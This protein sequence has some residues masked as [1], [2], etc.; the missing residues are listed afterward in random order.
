M[1]VL[2]FVS[3]RKTMRNRPS[4]I[5]HFY[6]NGTYSLFFFKKSYR[7][8]KLIINKKFVMILKW[9]YAFI[10][11]SLQLFKIYA[12][13]LIAHSHSSFILRNIWLHFSLTC[14]KRYIKRNQ[15]IKVEKNTKIMMSIFD[16]CCSKLEFYMVCVS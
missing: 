5:R 9:N 14:P 7:M 3:I 10:M 1:H 11:I 2:D 8:M 6:Q 13:I 4:K 12:Q 16:G 15:F